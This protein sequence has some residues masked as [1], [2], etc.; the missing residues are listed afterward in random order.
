MRMF[1]A[2]LNLAVL[3]TM[4]HGIAFDASAHTIGERQGASRRFVMP[5]APT[6][7][8]LPL[9]VPISQQDAEQTETDEAETEN[10]TS[11]KN[12]KR[13]TTVGYPAQ[14]QSIA[15]D[16]P[17]LIVKPIEKREQAFILR[18]VDSFVHGDGFRYDFEYYAFEPGQYNLADYLQLADGSI[19]A[20]LPNLTVEV[21][22]IKPAD[23]APIPNPLVQRKLGFRT[24]YLSVA[25]I[26]SIL[27]LIGLL[28]I[29][30]WGRGKTKR[31]IRTKKQK[32][33]ADRLR[34]LVDKA[35]RGDLD[36]REQAELERVIDS[37]WRKKLR[38]EHLPAKKFR[39]TLR[40]HP[41][42]SKL[43]SKLDVWLHRPRQN[44]D[45]DVSS[46]LE[47]FQQLSEED[48]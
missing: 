13:T 47:P 18:I 23:E 20:E 45:S 31:N 12:D 14:V 17:K 28:A 46:L 44:G 3:G 37:F 16:G 19:P 32:T 25:L 38:I 29:L 9:T 27:W 8:A 22:N 24:F 5:L 33:V 39:E 30:F 2:I 43:L 1:L 26:G 11:D 40:S 42:A 6:V 10:E 35:A 7:T 36:T 34:P 48:I 21:T 4:L 41:E 15:I